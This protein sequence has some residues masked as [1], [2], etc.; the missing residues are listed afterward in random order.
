MQDDCLHSSVAGVVERVNSSISV[1]PLKSRYHR[2]IG[3]VVIG[4][5]TEVVQKRWKLDTNARR[6]SILLLT[7]VNLPGGELVM[8]LF[9]TIS[10]MCVS[11]F[12]LYIEKEIS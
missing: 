9:S 7:S 4:R 2:E 5:I 10:K 12:Y 3:D 8:I 1:R 6:D 11:Y